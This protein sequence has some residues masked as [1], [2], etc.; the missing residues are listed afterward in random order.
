MP[1]LRQIV[2]FPMSF[3]YQSLLTKKKMLTR[4]ISEMYQ[5]WYNGFSWHNIAYKRAI[6]W[7]L[8]IVFSPLGILQ[9]DASPMQMPLNVEVRRKT[10]A[11]ECNNQY[12]LDSFFFK[13]KHKMKYL[14]H[15]IFNVYLW[16]LLKQFLLLFRQ[17]QTLHL[18]QLKQENDILQCKKR[19]LFSL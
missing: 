17:S 12:D 19:C 11:R 1:K 15:N 16:K 6:F 18:S 2:S 10:V 7:T 4:H 8:T 5:I 14:L 3:S 9:W 13:I